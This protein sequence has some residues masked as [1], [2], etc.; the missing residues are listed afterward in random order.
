MNIWFFLEQVAPNQEFDPPM[1]FYVGIGI[2]IAL[3]LIPWIVLFVYAII[4]KYRIRV[5]SEGFLIKTYKLKA[6]EKINIECP[7]RAG[8]EVEGLYRDDTF[9]L[10]LEDKVMPKK[11]LKVYIKWRKID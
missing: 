7:L 9:M 5:F 6:N 1:S 11:N 8:Y 2:L 4:K 3:M 10:P